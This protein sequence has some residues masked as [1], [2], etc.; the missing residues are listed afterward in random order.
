MAELKIVLRRIAEKEFIKNDKI[1]ADPSRILYPQMG[2]DLMTDP[3]KNLLTVVFQTGFIT[4]EKEVAA[5]LRFYFTVEISNLSDFQCADTSEKGKLDYR[6]PDGLL[7]AIL[8][9]VYATARVLLAQKL[10]NTRLEE[11]YLPFAGAAELIK[12]IRKH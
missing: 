5:L 12:L 9:D 10:T 3:G 8:T 2:F 6:L 11:I 4:S 7:E 1:L